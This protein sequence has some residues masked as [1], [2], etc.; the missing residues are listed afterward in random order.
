M[1]SQ[2]MDEM[3][4]APAGRGHRQPLPGARVALTLLVLINLFNY[5]DRYILAAVEPDIRE[6]L[7]SSAD[8]EEANVRAKM[9]LLTT[10]FMVS[11]VIAA[12]VFGWLAERVSRWLLIA[13]GVALWSMAS[14]ASGLADTFIVLLITRCF[15]GIGEG[16]Y[17][18]I[19]PALIADLYPIAK[20]CQ[21]LAWFYMAIPVGSAL[22]YAL[23]GQLASLRPESASWR[24]A[25]FAVIV[26]GVLLALWSLLMR[27]PE[28]GAVDHLIQPPRR[29]NLRDYLILFR[30]PSYVLDTLGMTAMTFSI[31]A[32]AFWMPGYLKILGVTSF[33]GL[34]ARMFFGIVT[35]G[36]GLTAT[37]TGGIAGDLLRQRFP[38]SYFLVSGIGLC[39]AVPCTLAFIAVPFP[40]AWLFVFLAEFCLFLNTGPSNTILVNVTHPSMRATGFAV[41]ILI[42][43]ILGDAISPPITGAIADRTSLSV[44]FMVISGFMLIGGLIWFWGIRY[45]DRD[46]AAAPCL[47]D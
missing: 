23:G 39:A 27:D 2:Y 22:G 47:L 15:V 7:L 16:A 35:A 12:P 1:A 3:P 11:Y 44:A 36:A 20:R 6:T 10:A 46:T 40:W 42:I 5:V 24:W 37:F 43:H 32:M 30:T 17:G 13:A 19:A 8:P 29:A 31:G 25:F 34:E 18:P 45:L 33:M 28:R 38:G 41:N 9:G 14:G 4:Q 21:V 26:P